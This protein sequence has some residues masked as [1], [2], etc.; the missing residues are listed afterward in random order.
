MRDAW[1]RSKIEDLATLFSSVI[2]AR[3]KRIL[4]MNVTKEN[5]NRLISVLPSMSAPTIAELV[6]GKGYALKV[7]VDRECVRTLIPQLKECGAS[8]ILEFELKKV[9]Q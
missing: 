4:E 2:L 8:D 3:R 5:L 6:G 1:K 9:I 7:G